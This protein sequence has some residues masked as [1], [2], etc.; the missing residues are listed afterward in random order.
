[1]TFPRRSLRRAQAL[2]LS[3]P[4]FSSAGQ[5]CTARQLFQQKL[6]ELQETRA[7][8]EAAVRRQIAATIGQQKQLQARR[9]RLAD[10]RAKLL[11]Q[12]K[13]LE[14]VDVTGRA[15]LEAQG[16]SLDTE[17]ARLRSGAPRGS[18]AAHS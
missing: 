12:R 13:Q 16:R 17:V 1:M 14:E 10:E 2:A 18:S 15:R 7:S 9:L 6:Q 5:Y 4:Y 11:R 3:Q 8:Q